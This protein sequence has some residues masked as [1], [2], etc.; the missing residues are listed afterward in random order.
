MS[1]C[2]KCTKIITKRSPG[3]ECS[4]CEK[5]VHCTT[6]CS[7]LTVKQLAAIRATDNLGWTCQE[8]QKSSSRPSIIIPQEDDDDDETGIMNKSTAQI[9]VK[10]LLMDISIEVDKC[11]NRAVKELQ[12][13]LQYQSDKMDDVLENI[14]AFKETIKDLQ[15]K[16]TELSNKNKNLETRVGAL[17]QRLQTFEQEKL[18]TLVEIANVPYTEGENTAEIIENAATFLQLPTSEIVKSRRIHG[19]VGRPGP[20]LAQ[21]KNEE[22]Q[23]KWLAAAKKI[24]LQVIDL[25]PTAPQPNAQVTVFIRE[26]L[27]PYNKKLLWSA[28]QQL[29]DTFRYVWCKKGIVMARKRDNDKTYVIIRCEED[30]KQLIQ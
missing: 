30:I 5:V 22:C 10:K 3:L 25:I 24:T 1:K 18:A 4:R 21:L 27:T 28:K 13:S 23:Q 20:I 8:C 7:A 14:E 9:D 11:I 29:K 16:N 12:D 19:K 26:A 17:E 6:P 15:R 2:E